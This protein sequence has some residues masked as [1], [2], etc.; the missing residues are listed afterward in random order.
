MHSKEL[1]RVSFKSIAHHIPLS[2]QVD[3]DALDDLGYAPLHYAVLKGQARV[4]QDLL[5]KGA[6]PNKTDQV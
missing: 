3:M 5:R 6:N 2:K 1:H 4:V